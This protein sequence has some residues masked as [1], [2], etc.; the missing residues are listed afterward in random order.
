[1]TDS[2]GD[3]ESVVIH[4]PSSTSVSPKTLLQSRTSLYTYPRKFPALPLLAELSYGPLLSELDSPGLGDT[5]VKE[6]SNKKA[7]V[8]EIKE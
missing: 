1:M 8:G 7:D 5:Y 6:V 3:G 4:T 2:R